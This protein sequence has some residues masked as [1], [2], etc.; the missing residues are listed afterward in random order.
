MQKEGTAQAK[1]THRA[2]HRATRVLG[3]TLSAVVGLKASSDQPYPSWLYQH[4]RLELAR[5][6]AM[7][8]NHCQQLATQNHR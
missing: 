5:P 7:P 6:S 2:T 3:L 1:A 8:A 4:A